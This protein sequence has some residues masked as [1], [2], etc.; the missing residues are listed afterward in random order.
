M[1]H[2]SRLPLLIAFAI[3]VVSSCEKSD[4][5]EALELP[6][7][8]VL[9]L[10]AGWAVSLEGYTAV[11]AAPAFD[12]PIEGHLRKGEVVEVVAKTNYRVPHG[13]ADSHWYQIRGDDVEGWV[14]GS[15]LLLAASREQAVN[16]SE[17]LLS[18]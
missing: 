17:D 3:T 8:P 4:D 16:A 15:E 12:A 6:T 10:R 1:R 7:T 14:Y 9:S 11:V 2:V 18:R 13:E 5:L